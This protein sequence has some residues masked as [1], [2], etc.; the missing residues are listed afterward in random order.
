MSPRALNIVSASA[1][2]LALLL[3]GLEAVRTRAPIPA[4]TLPLEDASAG[5]AAFRDRVQRLES[6]LRAS[7]DDRDL[8]LELAHLLHDGHR[9]DEA[10]PHYRRALELDPADPS[11]AYDLAGAY[12][13]LG[14][15]AE[16]EAVLRA[17][18]ERAPGDATALYD[19][20]AVRANRGDP[21]GARRWW[22]RARAATE[23]P[24]IR[25]RIHASEQKL[26]GR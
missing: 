24:E 20:G 7:P 18:I 12:G 19:L 22:A 11:A 1:A 23:D 2:A 13:T 17:R 6:A 21:V 3:L 8:H 4:R 15:W 5:M 16:A 25:G 10:L 14:R 9:V 26:G